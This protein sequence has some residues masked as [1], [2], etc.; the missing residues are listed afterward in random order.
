MPQGSVQAIV[1]STALVALGSN[2]PGE[3]GG[4]PEQ[5]VRRAIAVLAQ[6]AGRLTG[7]SRL[8][9]T[10]CFPPGAGPDYV[11][12]VVALDTALGPSDLLACLHR[13]EADFGRERRTRW[14][15]RT[16]DLDL[17]A[18]EGLVLPDPAAQTAW[19]DLPCAEQA[20]AT[21]DRLILP[22]PRLQDRAFVLVP[23]AD[24]AADWTHPLTGRTVTQML[25]ALPAAEVDAVRHGV[26]PDPD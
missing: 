2:L 18:V 22:H 21:P 26:L 25:A 1:T 16:L 3:H 17:L 14:G 15:M 9:E 8:Y 23:M 13:T 24:V 19:R 11:N 4:T 10:A 7:K 5:A 12:A 20:V 6:R